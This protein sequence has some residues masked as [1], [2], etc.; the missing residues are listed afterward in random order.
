VA[1]LVK[2]SKLVQHFFIPLGTGEVSLLI[3]LRYLD[4]GFAISLR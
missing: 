2:A 4:T 3:T 1:N